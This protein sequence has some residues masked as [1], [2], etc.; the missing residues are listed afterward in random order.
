MLGT[1]GARIG[2]GLLLLGAAFVAG[3]QVCSWR[4]EARELHSVEAARK[5]ERAVWRATVEKARADQAAAEAR[6][7]ELAA[8][9]SSFRAA[10]DLLAAELARG[11]LVEYREVPVRE[12]EPTVRVPARGARFR[13]CWNAGVTG[14]PADRAACEAARLHDGSA[15]GAVPPAGLVR[16]GDP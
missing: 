11:S 2:A 8:Q 9:L 15:P 10:T 3:W 4:T 14:S 16:P 13:L 1:L 7:A 12:G 6:G 5:V